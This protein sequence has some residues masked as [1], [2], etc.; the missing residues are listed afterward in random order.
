MPSILQVVIDEINVVEAAELFQQQIST[1]CQN[2]DI[3]IDFGELQLTPWA[4]LSKGNAAV[5]MM[6]ICVH[7]E[8]NDQSESSNESD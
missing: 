1:L 2:A 8:I 6:E 7:D 4:Y 5:I 3:N